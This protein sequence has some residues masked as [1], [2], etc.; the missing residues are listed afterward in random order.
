MPVR[1]IRVY[2]TFTGIQ[3]LMINFELFSFFKCIADGQVPS[4]A[5]Q[6][7][8]NEDGEKLYIGRAQHEGSLVVG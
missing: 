5:L 1:I 2:R 6:G 7:G 8:L 3:F 4:N